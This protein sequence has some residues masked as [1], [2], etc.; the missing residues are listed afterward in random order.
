MKTYYKILFTLVIIFSTSL[1]ATEISSEK[2]NNPNQIELYTPSNLTDSDTSY[3][4]LEI[5]NTE[6]SESKTNLE[7]AQPC[8]KICRKGKACGDSCISKKY[9]CHKPPGCAC[10]G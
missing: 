4:F 10:D 6:S 8:C 5:F 9:I 2:I 1:Y 3:N 7:Q